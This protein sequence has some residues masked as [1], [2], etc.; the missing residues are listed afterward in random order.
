MQDNRIEHVAIIGCGFIAR[1]HVAAIE[2]KYT[3][4][5]WYLCDKNLK[6]ACELQQ[7]IGTKAQIYENPKELLIAQKLD[8]A[9]VLTPPDSHYEIAKLAIENGAHV[10]VEKPMALTLEE[11]EGLYLLAD[12]MNRMLCVDHGLLYMEGISKARSLID[13]SEMGRVIGVHCFFGHSERKKTIPYGGVSHWAYRIPGGPLANLISHPASILVEFLG[14]PDTIYVLRDARNLMPC[15]SS[16]HLDVSI[17]TP[18]GH[19]SFSMSMAHGN[20]SRYVNIECEKGSIFVDLGR[21]LLI[22]RSQ[23]GRFGFISKAL[24]G[25]VEGCSYIYGVHRNIFRVAMKRMKPN[26]GTRELVMR[27]HEAVRNHLPCPVSKEN[28]LGVARIIEHVFRTG[29]DTSCQDSPEKANTTV[30]KP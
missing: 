19:G 5:K 15:G 14:W 23:A 9:H 13:T 11:T 17:R 30:V 27:F 20:S 24:S 4:S 10:L 21:Q 28:A 25:I 29:N 2:E 8:V 12:K 16:D 6:V 1:T 26:P 22:V 18:E 3:P 7:E